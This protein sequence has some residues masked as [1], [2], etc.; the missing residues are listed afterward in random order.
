M[1]ERRNRTAAFAVLALFGL[2]IAGWLY[3]WLLGV[4]RFW[5][6]GMLA[7][8]LLAVML[9]L[10]ALCAAFIR[11]IPVRVRSI[12]VL[13]VILFSLL[14]ELLCGVL[15]W[16]A[17]AFSAP[18]WICR[19]GGAALGA[20]AAMLIYGLLHG[21][22]MVLTR[23]TLET[24]LSVPD[25]EVRIALIS[26]VHMGLTIDEV[27]LKRELNRLAVEQPDVLIVAGDLADDWTTPEQ[28]RAACALV[29][30]FPAKHGVFFTYGNHDLASHGPTPPYT[31]AELDAALTGADVRI[32]DDQSVVSAGLNLVGRHDAGFSRHPERVPLGKLLAGLDR[33]L[34]V[35]C[36]D[37]QPRERQ[38]AAAAGVTL[39]LSGHTHAGQIWPMSWISRLSGA[40]YGHR[41]IGSMD[42]IISAGMGN[43]GSV[44]RSG[45]TAEMVLIR[46]IGTKQE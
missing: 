33:N 1:H 24:P 21:R 28:M 32:L 9:A 10:G 8:R 13:Y 6:A 44:L 20:T 38:E 25:G 34:P 19:G 16:A 29:G 4:L 12:A 2:G 18:G 45:C 46:L 11:P 41:R 7:A 23:Y 35:I 15:A 17:P 31:R 43:R 27:R 39:H 22:R 5:G 3:V 30:A 40:G 26:D 36:I 37:H 42:A 14:F